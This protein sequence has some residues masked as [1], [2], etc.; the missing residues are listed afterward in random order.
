MPRVPATPRQPCQCLTCPIFWQGWIFRKSYVPAEKKF[1]EVFFYSIAISFHVYIFPSCLTALKSLRN[2]YR[3]EQMKCSC[4]ISTPELSR[5][6]N[7]LPPTAGRPF[8]LEK[9][10]SK[11]ILLSS[12]S[13]RR[14]QYLEAIVARCLPGHWDARHSSHVTNNDLHSS[15]PWSGPSQA[16]LQI[17][18]GRRGAAGHC[19]QQLIEDLKLFS[20]N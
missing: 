9:P 12:S 11:W 20:C 10:G 5:H 6:F 1:V 2:F 16:S 4:R 3:W 14:A 8:A 7:V 13:L 15:A 19:E 17:C 18:A